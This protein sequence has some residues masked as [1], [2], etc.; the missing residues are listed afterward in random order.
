MHKIS[1]T[2]DE[3]NSKL[4]DNPVVQSEGQFSITLD[5]LVEDEV[6][7]LVNIFQRLCTRTTNTRFTI[8]K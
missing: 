4:D 1:I 8:F 3:E 5:E 7:E 6:S 2:K